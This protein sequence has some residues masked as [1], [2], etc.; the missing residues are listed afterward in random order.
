[1]PTSESNL[2]DGKNTNPMKNDMPPQQTLST[3]RRENEEKNK[4]G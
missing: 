4:K 3:K 1:M 2:D